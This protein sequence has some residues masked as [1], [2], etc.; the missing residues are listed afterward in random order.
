MNQVFNFWL[1]PVQTIELLDQEEPGQL[2]Q[3]INILFSLVAILLCLQ[4]YCTINFSDNSDKLLKAMICI[5]S[6]PFMYLFLNY[7]MAYLHLLISKLFQGESTIRQIRFV[8][9]FAI[10]PILVFLPF[11]IFQFF[12]VLLVPNLS[13][14]TYFS[15]ELERVF[16]ILIL[17]YLIIGLTKVN[18]F[19]AGYGL[20]VA[21]LA[22][23]VIE[24]L[25]M[26]IKS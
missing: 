1:K 11:V 16:S 3:T 17:C 20:A 4:G 22:P 26:L 10:S 7:F 9:A 6:I 8:L 19:S 5:L 21:I 24:L 2:N 25:R 14:S 12:L 23:S 13:A 18:R 15:F